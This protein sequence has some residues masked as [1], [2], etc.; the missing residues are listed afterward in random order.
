MAEILGPGG[1][2]LELLARV[3]GIRSVP[4]LVSILSDLYGTS[5]AD[6]E[7]EI[8]KLLDGLL[9]SRFAEEVVDNDV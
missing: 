1:A 8:D 2:E 5:D 7:P 3:A 6:I 4:E 9:A